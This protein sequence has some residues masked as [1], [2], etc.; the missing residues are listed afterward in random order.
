MRTKC[1]G[2]FDK[3]IIL[4]L[5]AVGFLTGCDK[6][7]GGIVAEY[8][9]PNADYELKGT[10]TDKTTSQSIQNI[11]VIRP[12]QSPEYGDTTYTDKDGKYHFVFNDFPNDTNTYQL[13]LEDIDGGENGGEFITAEVEGV[14]TKNDQVEKG[15][16]HWYDGKFV[17]TH[18]VVL[19][20][21]EMAVPEYGVLPASFKP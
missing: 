18:D 1:I 4:L 19:N 17:K 6:I 11:R 3:V 2:F 9:V 7:G 10:V 20:R 16:G 14:F 13:K 8:G 5:S 15:N 21:Q 12:V